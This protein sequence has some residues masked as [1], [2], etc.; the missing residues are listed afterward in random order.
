[1]IARADTTRCACIVILAIIF[2]ILLA[3]GSL[4]A[5][6]RTESA[7]VTVT[8][9][10]SWYVAAKAF[11][12]GGLYSGFSNEVALACAT[13]PCTFRLFWDANSESDLAGY[14]LHWGRATGV[15]AQSKTVPP[16]LPGTAL[17][18]T[19]PTQLRRRR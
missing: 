15:Y 7:E 14:V 8:E 1:M 3:V 17:P 13:A 10:G 9:A 6:V 16:S 2:S 19:A 4:F 5:Q 12:Q 18:P 11:N